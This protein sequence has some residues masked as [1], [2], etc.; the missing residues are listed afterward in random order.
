MQSR[1]VECRVRARE[2]IVVRVQRIL[3][4]AKFRAESQKYQESTERKMDH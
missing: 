2:L 1:E 3:Q 4:T